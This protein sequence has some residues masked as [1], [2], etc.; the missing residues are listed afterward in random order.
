MKVDKSSGSNQTA[1][2]RP[3]DDSQPAARPAP[4]TAPSDEILLLGVPDTE[5]T[6]KVRNALMTLLEEVRALR[7]ELQRSRTRID[8]LE[9]LAD[10]DPTLDIL[11]RRAF[12]RELDRA[13]G[14]IERYEMS[15]SLVF[16]DLND[17]KTIN[18]SNGHAA[19]DAALAH[20]AAVIAGNI[21]QTDILA[22][23]G[24]DEFALLLMQA[25]QPLAVTKA[26]ALADMIAATPVEWSGDA[27]DIS[28][29]CGA[30]EIKAGAS[31][32]EVIGLADEAMYKAKREK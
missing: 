9:A 25:D 20:V 15:A 16:I 22:R 29:S 28:V 7:E 21:R 2:V 13:L 11:N 14:M 5:L 8:E 3:R 23:L 6:P 26:S 30:V 12:A 31:A 32:D 18:D 19:G 24:G 1:P 10:R 17:L 27:F 4:A